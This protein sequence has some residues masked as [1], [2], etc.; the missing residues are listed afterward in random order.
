MEAEW[1]LMK[2]IQLVGISSSHENNSPY[3]KAKKMDKKVMHLSIEKFRYSAFE[4][5]FIFRV[6]IPKDKLFFLF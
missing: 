4:G 2:R 5:S 6:H 1:Q 3:Q